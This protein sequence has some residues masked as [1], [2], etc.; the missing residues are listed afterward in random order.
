MQPYQRGIINQ[1]NYIFHE[2]IDI[3]GPRELTEEDFEITEDLND[4]HEIKDF[5]TSTFRLKNKYHFQTYQPLRNKRNFYQDVEIKLEGDPSTRNP[6]NTYRVNR[7]MN[8]YYGS[9]RTLCQT[10][11]AEEISK[12]K[13]NRNKRSLC[14]NCEKKEQFKGLCNDCKR[15]EKYK[16]LCNE[17]KREEKYKGLCNECKRGEKNKKKKKVICDECQQEESSKKINKK[18]I[19]HYECMQEDQKNNKN[20]MPS[21]DRRLE[22]DNIQ[23]NFNNDGDQIN[24]GYVNAPFLAEESE[25]NKTLNDND[26]K[27]LIDSILKELNKNKN[28]GDDTNLKITFKVLNENDKKKIVEEVKKQIKDEEQEK[29]FNSLIYML[30]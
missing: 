17:C 27:V 7:Q 9:S 12:N 30:E 21:N 11:A 13:Y 4:I 1:K 10:C 24:I 14:P 16:G 8:N 18:Q 22:D 2:I 28:I 23:A 25:D 6:F 15:E 26:R 5:N 3:K 20:E 29:K 19:L